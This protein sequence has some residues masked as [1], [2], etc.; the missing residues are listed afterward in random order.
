MFQKKYIRIIFIK[1]VVKTILILEKDQKKMNIAGYNIRIDEP[2]RLSGS[3]EEAFIKVYYPLF[4]V[5]IVEIILDKMNKETRNALALSSKTAYKFVNEY[6]HRK[7]TKC[8]MNIEETT[9]TK[10]LGAVFGRDEIFPHRSLTA[11]TWKDERMIQQNNDRARYCFTLLARHR[12]T[13]EELSLE[14]SCLD[15]DV[16]KGSTVKHLSEMSRLMAL[17]KL[18]LTVT[19]DLLSTCYGSTNIEY[20]TREIL[21]AP[22]L[23]KVKLIFH[24]ETFLLGEEGPGNTA[25]PENKAI[26]KITIISNGSI[27][28][29]EFVKFLLKAPNCEKFAIRENCTTNYF[30]ENIITIINTKNDMW[31]TPKKKR[32][33]DK[34]EPSNLDVQ[35]LGIGRF[36]SLPKMKA[37]TIRR[38][39]IYVDSRTVARAVPDRATIADFLNEN[40]QIM[41][42]IIKEEIKGEHQPL[43]LYEDMMW[44]NYVYIIQL[45]GSLNFIQLI[46]K[47]WTR[48]INTQEVP[49]VPRIIIFKLTE[50]IDAEEI[51]HGKVTLSLNQFLDRL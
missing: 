9:K 46:A 27:L 34:M 36:A 38:I 32:K 20:I 12:L 19:K 10:D 5:E 42:I 8:Q 33:I 40:A 24:G 2:R 31:T 4:P 41:N 48:I 11:I 7:K 17:K 25:Y 30:I 49:D 18:T 39:K 14:S 22:A 50:I 47:T 45:K 3:E 1:K 28:S 16:H 51:E 44:T 29:D 43:K 13:L 37:P 21:S 35:S 6:R 23:E 26:K 15:Y